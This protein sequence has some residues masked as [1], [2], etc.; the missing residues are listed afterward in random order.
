MYSLTI[1]FQSPCLS[2]KVPSSCQR[3]QCNYNNSIIVLL[4]ALQMVGG[5]DGTSVL[6]PMT[7][8]LCPLRNQNK[9]FLRMAIA[10]DTVI[11]S[12]SM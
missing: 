1:F 9:K 7:Q 6:L 5:D 8:F 3:W 4:R 12:Y 2:V 10:K 11:I